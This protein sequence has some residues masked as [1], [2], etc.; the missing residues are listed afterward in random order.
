MNKIIK[1]LMNRTAWL[2]L[3][4]TLHSSSLLYLDALWLKIGM[5][6]MCE[7]QTLTDILNCRDWIELDTRFNMEDLN[8]VDETMFD[9]SPDP[10]YEVNN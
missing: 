9:E 6:P 3:L 2:F 7:I 10:L 1:F 5:K 8:S 4:S